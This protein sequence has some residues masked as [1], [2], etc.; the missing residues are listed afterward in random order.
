[1]IA[2]ATPAMPDDAPR[3]FLL[4]E[5]HLIEANRAIDAR[6]DRIAVVI[7]TSALCWLLPALAAAFARVPA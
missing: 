4:L 6:F 1:M 2:P 7:G 3:A 5:S